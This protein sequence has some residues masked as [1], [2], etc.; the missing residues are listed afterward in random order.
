MLVIAATILFALT[1]VG[2]VGDYASNFPIYRLPNII[3]HIILYVIYVYVFQEYCVKKKCGVEVL[4]MLG[5]FGVFFSI[6][7][8]YPFFIF[9]SYTNVN[10]FRL[11]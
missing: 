3:R 4:A 5:V 9:L 11:P 7:E 2:E 8:M 1:N 6:I 10:I